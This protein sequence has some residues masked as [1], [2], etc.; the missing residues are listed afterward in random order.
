M[1]IDTTIKATS[2][3]HPTNAAGIAIIDAEVGDVITLNDTLAENPAGG[4]LW[5]AKFIPSNL[6]SPPSIANSTAAEASFT[7]P[8]EGGY[9]IRLR[10]MLDVS[11]IESEHFIFIGCPDVDGNIIPCAGL[12]ADLINLSELIQELG[13]AG[14][15]VVGT[16]LLEQAVR[17][18]RDRALETAT[19]VEIDGTDLAVG[20][21]ATTIA[22][23]GQAESIALQATATAFKALSG[24]V[25]LVVLPDFS[26]GGGT[27]VAFGPLNQS[28]V[29]GCLTPESTGFNIGT[30]LQLTGGDGRPQDGAED[31]N[32]GLPVWIV[33]GGPGSGGGGDPGKH[34]FIGITTD[35]L[36]HPVADGIGLVRMAN[37]VD[38]SDVLIAVQNR[39]GIAPLRLISV[40][41]ADALRIG[42]A[43]LGNV[44]IRMAAGK[45]FS[46]TENGTAY[47]SS[48]AAGFA[49]TIGGKQTSLDAT[50]L[51]LGEGVNEIAFDAATTGAITIGQSSGGGADLVVNSEADLYLK[52]AGAD[53]VTLTAG[54]AIFAAATLVTAPGTWLTRYRTIDQSVSSS[55]TLVDDDTLQLA[56]NASEV[57]LVEAYLYVT[58]SAGGGSRHTLS[59]PAGASGLI[60]SDLLLDSAICA[61][62][63]VALGTEINW[64]TG[65]AG[66][67]IYMRSVVTI[68]GT[69]GSIKVKFAQNASDGTATKNKTGSF[70]KATRL[71]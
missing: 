39:A 48:S 17:T 23:G 34:S 27:L 38:H 20:G 52:A 35:R 7:V 21:P 58:S 29:V 47:L 4:R 65:G 2:V 70:L 46:A 68:G 56:V 36:S 71:A 37:P 53:A 26:G 42:D 64:G 50:K 54:A 44:E 25:G 31:N 33:P 6:D 15:D 12:D 62:R 43:T 63:S 22:I 30:G 45:S 24:G 67:N 49:V 66:A 18:T 40:L 14:G 19:M 41:A 61:S 51:A 3:A 59:G 28:A 60:I 55:V 69:A 16:K 32:D 1:S 5:S 10:R 57:W 11:T 8:Q 13:W 9:V